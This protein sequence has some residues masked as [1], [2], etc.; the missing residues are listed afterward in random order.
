MCFGGHQV[1]VLAAHLLDRPSENEVIHGDLSDSD[2]GQAA[3]AGGRAAASL[4][5]GYGA[6]T[7]MVLF[8]RSIIARR[9]PQEQRQRLLRIWTS[10]CIW[11]RSETSRCLP[12]YP[13]RLGG[14]ESLRG[15]WAGR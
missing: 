8:Q 6:L 14:P 11:N 4:T 9:M 1:G 2:A 5:W 12:A 15:V 3:K 13:S 10:A 7:A